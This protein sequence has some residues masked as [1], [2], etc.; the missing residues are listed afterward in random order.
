MEEYHAGRLTEARDLATAAND[1]IGRANQ[2][3]TLAS[4][5]RN[6]HVKDVNPCKTPSKPLP[7]YL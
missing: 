6:P 5:F 3:S 4:R 7:P 2:L 1:A